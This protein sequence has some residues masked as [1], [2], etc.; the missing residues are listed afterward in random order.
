[1]VIKIKRNEIETVNGLI[2]EKTNTKQIIRFELNDNGFDFA[3]RCN[4][5]KAIIIYYNL[6]CYCAH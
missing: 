5:F 4:H 6:T 1:M 2:V 3:F